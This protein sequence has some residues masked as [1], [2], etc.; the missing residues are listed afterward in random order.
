M[1]DNAVVNAF[2]AKNLGKAKDVKEAKTEYLKRMSVAFSKVAGP[3]FA[4]CEGGSWEM[5][6]IEYDTVAALNPKNAGKAVEKVSAAIRAEKSPERRGSKASRFIDRLV[7]DRKF[8]DAKLFLDLIP[9]AGR[10]AMTL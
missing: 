10:S 9:G 4:K 3:V 6:L 1:N 8:T 5:L 2:Y 7:R